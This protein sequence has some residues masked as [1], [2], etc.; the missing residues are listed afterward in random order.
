MDFEEKDKLLI[1]AINSNIIRAE[2]SED[3][4]TKIQYGIAV[5]KD[6]MSFSLVL[7]T[8]GDY[9]H[10]FEYVNTALNINRIITDMICIE[11]ELVYTKLIEEEL[12]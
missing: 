6:A 3:T 4:I 12:K 10:S 5:I 1:K 8:R 7:K 2:Q 11:Q 9:K